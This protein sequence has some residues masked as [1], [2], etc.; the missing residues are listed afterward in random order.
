MALLSF[1]SEFQA[2]VCIISLYIAVPAPIYRLSKIF[3]MFKI[4]AK[5]MRTTK[6]KSDWLANA[7]KL[8]TRF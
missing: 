1:F 8:D 5:R 7:V 2:G 3:S 6:T 4:L